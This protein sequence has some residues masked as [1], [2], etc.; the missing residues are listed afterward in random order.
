MFYTLWLPAFDHLYNDV[1]TATSAR[2]CGMNDCKYSNDVPTIV[3]T[4]DI[5]GGPGTTPHY[6]LFVQP[7]VSPGL[8]AN[9]SPRVLLDLWGKRVTE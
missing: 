8:Y 4:Y 2:Q 3:C 1:Y 6:S 5:P 7:Y 9:C